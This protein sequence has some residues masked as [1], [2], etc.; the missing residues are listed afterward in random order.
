MF[1]CH[2]IHNY[3]CQFQF[4]CPSS[5]EMPPK[6]SP[7]C[8]ECKKTESLL[9]RPIENGQLC[10]ACSE[11]REEEQKKASEVTNIEDK[12]KKMTREVKDKDPKEK[13]ES[14]VV[15]A[16]VDDKCSRLRKST[17]ATRFKA[18]PSTHNTTNGNGSEKNSSGGGSSSKSQ[19]KGRNRR[20]LFKRVP[21]K[22]PQA[23]ATTHSV[24]S[25]FHKV[26]SILL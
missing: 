6:A 20:S 10:L 9:W 8:V 17:R 16:A 11:L 12:N 3:T 22:T 4:I 19:T 23:Q 26:S 7:I 15:P 2:G 14:S 1:I 18:K 25:V 21:Y 13:S 24:E 5:F